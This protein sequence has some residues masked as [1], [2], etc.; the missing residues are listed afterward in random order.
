MALG[1]SKE[2]DQRETI[3]RILDQV[4]ENSRRIRDVEQ[5]K[6][7]LS[8]GLRSIEERVMGLEDVHDED[9]QDLKSELEEL[10][11]SIMKLENTV[12]KIKERLEDVAMERDVEEIKNFVDLF[13]PLESEFM[14]ESEVR[15]LI[16]EELNSKD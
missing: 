8:K 5:D 7:S 2:S 16:K 13:S 14:T 11:T 10:S 4:K 6:T 1:E 12:S 9:K 3:N 15:T